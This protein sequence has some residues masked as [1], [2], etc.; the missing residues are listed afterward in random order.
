M[1]KVRTKPIQLEKKSA[2]QILV[3]S[4]NMNTMWR[5]GI[6]LVGPVSLTI[7]T[8]ERTARNVIAQWKGYRELATSESA[9]A[10]AI[11]KEYFDQEGEKVQVINGFWISEKT[12]AM[13]ESVVS[14]YYCEVVC[15]YIQV[16]NDLPVPNQTL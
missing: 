11:G 15:I 8:D 4:N 5:V 7:V 9:D 14:F 16:A 12:G 2:M 13:H 3:W 6:S 1:K 10:T